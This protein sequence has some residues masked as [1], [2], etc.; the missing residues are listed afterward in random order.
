MPDR[1]R[2]VELGALAAGFAGAPVAQRHHTR[3]VASDPQ[4]AIL[5]A[6]LDGGSLSATSA[7][8]TR[9]H[10]EVFGTDAA[11]ALVLLHGWTEDT[12][13]WTYMIP[14]LA[15]DFRVIA[16][17][18]R[19][20]GRSEQAAGGD[21]SLARF[22]ED[23]EAVLKATVPEDE[24]AIIAGHSLGAMSIAAWAEHH[25]VSARAVGAALLFTVVDGLIGG[26]VVVHVP[27]AFQALNE[28]VARRAVMG[29]RAPLPR[30]STPISA[31]AIKH[32]AFGPAA[33]PAQVA[34]VE[35][36]L[37]ACPPRV[38]AASGLAMSDMD[39][40]HALPRLTVPTLVMAGTNDRLTPPSHAKR[41][42]K[43][44]PHLQ[45]LIELPATGHMGPLER[46][47][48]VSKALRKL[49]QEAQG[50]RPATRAHSREAQV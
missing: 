19:G 4:R 32:A 6:P 38:R 7:D 39:L 24:R 20:H 21:C 37:V 12:R 8:G 45:A 15:R 47:S 50:Q 17:N 28:Q 46:P 5:E 23:L 40:L 18:L 30:F 48:E 1:R 26:Q 33:T 13:L 27:R 31:A 42:A 2:L 34:L 35:R 49:S 3:R 14:E 25:D 43:Q 22:G 16:P 10:I 9:L 11:P 41:I 29:S 36:M 44:L